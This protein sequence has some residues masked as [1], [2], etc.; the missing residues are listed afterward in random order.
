M[1]NYA[2]V[3]T[4]FV[5]REEF[6]VIE[7]PTSG[8][9]IRKGK[10]EGDMK[11]KD[12]A[13]VGV[14]ALATMFIVLAVFTDLS[15]NGVQIENTVKEKIAWPVLK[16]GGLEITLQSDKTSYKAGDKPI[17]QLIVFNTS[18]QQVSAKITVRVMSQ[19][20]VSPLSRMIPVA[21]EIFTRQQTLD[22]NHAERESVL[23]E[24]DT[25]LSPNT[26]VFLTLSAGEQTIHSRIIPVV[27]DSDENKSKNG[28]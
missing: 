15:V 20:K 11:L 10:G 5:R 9:V 18:E 23:I 13:I 8:K 25:A 17:I 4:S 6:E 22:I 7:F 28:F 19:E 14:A 3:A 27:S 24:T 16:Q 26:D 21:N 12:A 1:S 2:E